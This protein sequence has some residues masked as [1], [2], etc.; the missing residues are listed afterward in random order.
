[1]R[2]PV[3]VFGNNI[4][5]SKILHLSNPCHH[6]NQNLELNSITFQITG[7]KCMIFELIMWNHRLIHLLFPYIFSFTDFLPK[8]FLGLFTSRVL[9][10][11]PFFSKPF[12]LGCYRTFIAGMSNIIWYTYTDN[13]ISLSVPLFLFVYLTGHSVW[14]QGKHCAIFPL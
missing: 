5:R 10:W 8:I 6:T 11:I 3:G 9:F 1:M 14:T 12:N 13:E 7:V 2:D 4:L